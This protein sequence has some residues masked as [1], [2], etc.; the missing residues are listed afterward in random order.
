M[1]GGFLNC[2]R[3]LSSLEVNDSYP[4]GAVKNTIP[5]KLPMSIATLFLIKPRW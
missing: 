3:L 5:A 1:A 4:R 2:N